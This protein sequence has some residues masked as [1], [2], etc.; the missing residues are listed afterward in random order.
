MSVKISIVYVIGVA[1][2]VALGLMVLGVKVAIALL[3]AGVG[4][5]AAPAA[6]RGFGTIK[7]KSV[8]IARKHEAE[9]LVRLKTISDQR[10]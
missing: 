9:L 7:D 5:A 6:I 2:F 8:A 10:R 1:V 3:L 4:T